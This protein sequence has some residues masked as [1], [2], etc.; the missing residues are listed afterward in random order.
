MAVLTYKVG[1]SHTWLLEKLEE[2]KYLSQ[3]YEA[4]CSGT[5]VY[6][7][8][9]SIQAGPS[10]VPEQPVPH[11]ETLPPPPAERIGNVIGASMKKSGYIVYFRSCEGKAID[12]TTQIIP[13]VNTQ[14]A[15][16]KRYTFK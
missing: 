9:F 5:V 15:G 4:P 12:N 13:S 3:E 2:E 1:L 16:K 8:N 6:I 11:S 14:K 7:C 10:R